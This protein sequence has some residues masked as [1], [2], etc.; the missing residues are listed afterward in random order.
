MGD[1]I[2]DLTGGHFKR[3]KNGIE[4]GKNKEKNDND[5]TYSIFIKFDEDEPLTLYKNINNKD[6]V[7]FIITNTNDEFSYME[8]QCPKTGKKVKIFAK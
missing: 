7:E 2:S 6:A 4:T 5:G 3:G 1:I 8:F